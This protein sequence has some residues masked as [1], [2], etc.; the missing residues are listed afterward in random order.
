MRSENQINRVYYVI[1]NQRRTFI[2][3]VTFWDI[4]RLFHY[5]TIIL[6]LHCH[7]KSSK[8][9][10]L[11]FRFL[12]S[13]YRGLQLPFFSNNDYFLVDV[14]VERRESN[15]HKSVITSI[16]SNAGT[17][18]KFKQISNKVRIH[19]QCGYKYA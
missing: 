10:L 1:V 9:S 4:E 16:K 14:D 2:Q 5:F 8:I 17:S 6:L 13:S 15:L 18:I 3:K 7:P 11:I 19:P 12:P